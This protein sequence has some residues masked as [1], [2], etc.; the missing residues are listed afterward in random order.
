MFQTLLM[1]MNPDLKVY[2]TEI[3]LENGGDMELL[4]SGM[5]C[6]AEVVIDQYEKATYIPVQAV[7]S[8]GGKQTVYVVK[9]SRLKPR[10]VETGMDNNIVI[11]IASGLEPGEIV[12]LSPPL[13]QAAVVEQS[14]EKLSDVSVPTADTTSTTQGGN[15]NTGSGTPPMSGGNQGTGQPQGGNMPSVQS[16]NMPSGQSGNMPSVQ[17]GNMPSGQSGNLPSGQGDNMPSGQSGNMPSGQGG[18]FITRFDKDSDGKISK[19]EFLG[20][21]NFFSQFDK[22]SDGYISSDEAPQGRPSNT[23]GQNQ[24]ANQGANQSNN[25]GA[26]QDLGSRYSTTGSISDSGSSEG[27]PS[28]GGMPGGGGGMPGGF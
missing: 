25:Q 4:R 23:Q 28:G 8:V 21:E 12:S 18:N 7:M 11:R 2:D 14:F 19:S 10:T 27:E 24:G 20:P 5:S 15:Q 17:S 16:G 13:A 6:T 26:N 3:T 22:N 9:G 1:H